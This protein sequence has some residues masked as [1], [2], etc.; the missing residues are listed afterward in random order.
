M[1]KY[2]NLPEQVIKRYVIYL[3]RDLGY[4]ANGYVIIFFCNVPY[5]FQ[6]PCE[7]LLKISRC[8]ALRGYVHN[9]FISTFSQIVRKRSR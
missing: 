1:D 5:E 7:I 8:K 6:Y 9:I 2:V 4:K 3:I